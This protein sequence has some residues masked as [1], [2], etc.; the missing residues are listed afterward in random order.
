M[1]DFK[2]LNLDDVEKILQILSH[3]G[4]THMF[5]RAA[6]MIHTISTVSPSLPELLCE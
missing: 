2:D 6:Q 5:N 4:F 3:D 1:V